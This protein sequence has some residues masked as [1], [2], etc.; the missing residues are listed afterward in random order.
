[1]LL[2]D[3]I[4]EAMNRYKASVRMGD[5]CCPPQLAT[6][7][8]DL[9][10]RLKLFYTDGLRDKDLHL[11]IGQMLMEDTIAWP[12]DALKVMVDFI[13]EVA[14]GPASTLVI[15]NPREGPDWVCPSWATLKA[16]FLR[17]TF[18]FKMSA[19]FSYAEARYF[20]ACHNHPIG[21]QNGKIDKVMGNFIK[22]ISDTS[23]AGNSL[24]PFPLDVPLDLPDG[25]PK[26]DGMEFDTFR[27]QASEC[28]KKL[29]KHCFMMLVDAT[30]SDGLALKDL[31]PEYS[32]II[33]AD[34]FNKS[35]AKR[36][37]VDSDKRAALEA[38]TVSMFTKQAELGRLHKD[39]KLSPPLRDDIEIQEQ[40][41][42]L[43]VL[44]GTA[45]K[46]LVAISSVHVLLELKGLTQQT[47]ASRLLA[48]SKA[49]IPAMLV[50]MLLKACS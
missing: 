27:V 46:A 33:T 23:V 29:S 45:R 47:E 2:I 31:T 26:M 13:E 18:V 41:K 20:D 8:P 39:W 30:V 1:M 3:S 22:V 19:L 50:P 42:T 24:P 15:K 4:D 38:A 49:D 10:S 16:V 11:Q 25:F 34:N 14:T 9:C 37:L 12:C 48:N 43:D 5:V 40:I 35:L 6:E 28:V 17:A 21:L 7:T 44:Y 32:H 36:H